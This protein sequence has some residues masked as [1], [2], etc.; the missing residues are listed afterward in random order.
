M[1]EMKTL[2][3][4][5]FVKE[6]FFEDGEK[7]YYHPIEFDAEDLREIRDEAREWVKR[8]RNKLNPM[9]LD[10]KSVEEAFIDFFNLDEVEE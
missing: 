9:Y 5:N 10:D 4:L 6:M 3:D 8:L 1:S 7:S 2:K